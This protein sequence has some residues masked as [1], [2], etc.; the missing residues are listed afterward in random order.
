MA[1]NEIEKIYRKNRK[2]WRSWL[3]KNHQ[4]IPSVW[5]VQYKKSANKPTISWVEAVEEAIC[6]GWIDSIRKSIDEERFIQFFT[7]RKPKSAW[8]KINKVKV[9]E[10]IEAGLMTEAGYESITRAKEMAHGLFWM[11]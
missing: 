2:E 7:K 1:S 4:S 3:E 6:F 9:L 10:L 5:L 8:S 11:K